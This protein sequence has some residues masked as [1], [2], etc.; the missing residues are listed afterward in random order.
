MNE[1]RVLSRLKKIYNA[2]QAMNALLE[3]QNVEKD[4]SGAFEIVDSVLYDVKT[5]LADC[6]RQVRIIGFSMQKARLDL[7][8]EQEMLR[9][10]AALQE[11]LQTRS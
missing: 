9:E 2:L 11:E 6:E 4:A 5:L 8:K 7:F 3:K 1:Q 10:I